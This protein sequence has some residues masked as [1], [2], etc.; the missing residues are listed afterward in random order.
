MENLNDDDFYISLPKIELHAHLNGSISYSTMKK[1]INYH[2]TTWPDEKLPENSAI[3]FKRGK[4]GSL[5][6]PFEIFTIIHSVTDNTEAIRMTTHDVIREFHAD[7]VKYLELRS[8]PREVDGRMSKLQY[9]ETIIKEIIA[10]QE[11]S[12]LDI[13]VNLLLSIDRRKLE[14]FESTVQL[15]YNLKKI[16]PDI[17]VGLDISG[18]P[19]I[20]DITCIIPQLVKLRENN[21]KVTIHLAEVLNFDETL[22]FLKYIPDR[23]GHGTF[24]H[25]STGGHE[26]LMKE[27]SLTPQPVEVCLT[28]N[29][30]SGSVPSYSKHQARY[31]HESNIPIILCT[32][33]KGV[34]SCTLS[35]EYK[36]AAEH[37][38]WSREELFTI[39]YNAIK[40][41][42]CSDH[43]K[44]HLTKTWNSW[45][46]K[47]NKYF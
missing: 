26:T 5:D 46:D 25:P 38:D 14:C 34:F 22:N 4:D 15:Y 19:R 39:S 12:D 20:N 11:D 3:V 33:D 7:N 24:I 8:T 32:D 36:L 40:F 18:D 30:I 10:A 47:N 31:L 23:I 28:S 44:E 9:C 16:Y 37:F 29:I 35:R 1:L 21:V 6:K 41:A 45:R 13:H 17:V 42:F 2:K 27:L 43:L